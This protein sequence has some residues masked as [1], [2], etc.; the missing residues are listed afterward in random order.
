MKL[1]SECIRCGIGICVFWYCKN[2]RFAQYVDFIVLANFEVSVDSEFD[3]DV[4]SYIYTALKCIRETFVKV[5]TSAS[6]KASLASLR[7][8][9]VL[10]IS[11]CLKCLKWFCRYMLK[12]LWTLKLFYTHCIFFSALQF[13][14]SFKY[15]IMSPSMR[16]F[17]FVFSFGSFE[18]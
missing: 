7:S 4:I 17:C 12:L 15:G 14:F 1:V 3:T 6:V 11:I 18:S 5:E 2:F 10:R 8:S 9:W 16:I 13:C